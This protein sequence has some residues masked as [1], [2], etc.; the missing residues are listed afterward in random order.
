MREISKNIF[1]T[2]LNLNCISGDWHRYNLKRKVAEL[3]VVSLEAFEERKTAHEKEAKIAE[4]P[5][6]ES[7]LYC[8][9]C[10]KNFKNLKM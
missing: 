8:I 10:G 7:K 9:A 4:N 5:D 3:P 6:K 2:I 1:G